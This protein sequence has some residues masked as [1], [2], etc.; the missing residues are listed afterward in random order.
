MPLLMVIAEWLYLKTGDDVYY[1]LARRWAVGTAITFAF[2]AVSARK[3]PDVF[4]IGDLAS[5]TSEGK[6]VPGVAPAAHQEGLHA[7]RNIIWAIRVTP[8]SR[9]ATLTKAR[10]RASDAVPRLPTSAESVC[11]DL[12]RG[13]RG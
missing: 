12:L 8:S 5:I 6:P 9:F 7:A 13:S 10:L 2:G 11:R 3:A 4:V 1:T